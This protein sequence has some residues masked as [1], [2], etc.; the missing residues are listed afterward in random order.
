VQALAVAQDGRWL[1]SASGVTI[2]VWNVA[3][4]QT[5][6]LMRVDA[7]IS[8]CAWLGSHAL[9]VGGSAGLYLFDFLA[10]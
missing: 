5:A 6:A 10:T 2:R 3:T 9:A 4:A 1:A 7:R 8:T